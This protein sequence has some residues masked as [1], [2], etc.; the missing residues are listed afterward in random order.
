MTDLTDPS[1]TDRT[2][3]A[4]FE[5]A[6][7]ERYVPTEYSR[8]PW[9]PAHCHGG[10]IAALL[11]RAVERCDPGDVDWHV[12]RLT[13]ELTRPVPVGRPLTLTSRL[14]R[15]GRRVS[16]VAGHLVDGD[17][18]VARVRGLRIRRDQLD[19]PAV[20][21]DPA[22]GEFP[23]APDD[24]RREP[25]R[26][27]A[28]DPDVVSFA[29]SASEHRFAAGSWIEPGP[30]AVWIRLTVPV[31]PDE[32]P[33]GTQRV[34]AA[35]DFGNGVSSVLPWDEFVFINPDLTVHLVRPADGEW[36]GLLA[37]TSIGTHG[38]GLAQ[39][40]LH[41]TVGP[42]GRSLQSLYVAPR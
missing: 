16:L 31:L 19:V 20:A 11:A 34:A 30:V 42:V 6:G 28:D 26:L 22:G 9:D 35:A 36:I 21:A 4:L 3:G 5:P 18:E 1:S 29:R 15:P 13:I 24:S 12:A 32:V 33:T 17:T 41:D 23:A 38:G 7:G 39:S 37:S 2:T 10:P 14:E 27:T 40:A 8:G 25:L